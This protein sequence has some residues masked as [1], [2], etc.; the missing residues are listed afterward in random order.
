MKEE[1]L[2]L[3]STW[4][5]ITPINQKRKENQNGRDN[6]VLLPIGMSVLRRE[7]L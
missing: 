5:I 1:S 7:H 2:S 4:L 3:Y 6:Y